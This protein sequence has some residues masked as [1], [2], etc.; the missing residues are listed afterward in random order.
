MKRVRLTIK[1]LVVLGI[2]FSFAGVNSVSAT[3]RLPIGARDVMSGL[4]QET[5]IMFLIVPALPLMYSN[6]MMK[7]TSNFTSIRITDNCRKVPGDRLS[8]IATPLRRV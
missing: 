2:I 8:R 1:A 3:G 5:M 7:K 4:V 6:L